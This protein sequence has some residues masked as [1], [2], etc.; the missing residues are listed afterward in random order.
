MR[1]GLAGAALLAA[2]LLIGGCSSSGGNTASS[3]SPSA[4]PSASP[5]ASAAICHD[6]NALR[7]SLTELSHISPG[8]NALGKL[9]TDL[10]NVKTN[11]DT[12]R[13]TA[14]DQ[15]KPQIDA[16]TSA[17]GKLQKTLA[18]L[19]S[20]PSASAAAK[21]VSTDLAAVTTAGSNLLG[22][23]SIRCPA[24]SSSPSA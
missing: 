14:G 3:P 6:V 1:A 8:A 16:L 4:S 2:A 9:K 24:A 17:L 19:G 18:N 12:L 5:G 11:L 21:A 23:A 15:W 20:Q 7:A 13:S 22:T 10:T